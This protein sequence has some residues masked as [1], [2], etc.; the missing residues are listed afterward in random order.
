MQV[1]LALHIVSRSLIT[2]VATCWRIVVD[3][4]LDRRLSLV[5]LMALLNG[6]MPRSLGGNLCCC[7]VSL[8]LTQHILFNI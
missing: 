3:P 4:G 5:R 2:V 1:L 8:I 6:L 7:V